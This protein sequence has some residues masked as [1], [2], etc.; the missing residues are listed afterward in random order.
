MSLCSWLSAHAFHFLW[1]RW[2]SAERWAVSDLLVSCSC[3]IWEQGGMEKREPTRSTR[4]TYQRLE[5]WETEVH[6]FKHRNTES[7]RTGVLRAE[8]GAKIEAPFR[9]IT[10]PKRQSVTFFVGL[11]RLVSSAICSR[12]T[13]RITQAAT[14]RCSYSLIFTSAHWSTRKVLLSL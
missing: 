2:C 7:L 9:C 8:R 4:G 13:A 14:R 10:P 6:L 12:N 3:Q 5:H 1:L 11:C